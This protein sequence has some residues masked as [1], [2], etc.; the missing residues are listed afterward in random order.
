MLDRLQQLGWITRTPDPEDRRR[1]TIKLTGVGRRKAKAVQT[2]LGKA[3]RQLTSSLS[4][5]EQAQLVKLLAKIG[6]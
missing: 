5:R 3:E 6:E 2:A 1:N 4:E